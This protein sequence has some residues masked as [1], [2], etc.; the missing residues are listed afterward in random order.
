MSHC[1]ECAKIDRTHSYFLTNPSGAPLIYCF[2]KHEEG[3]FPY[4]K[5]EIGHKDAVNNI[6]F[7]EF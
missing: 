6:F 2:K 1:Q 5:L 4:D 3:N 7:L